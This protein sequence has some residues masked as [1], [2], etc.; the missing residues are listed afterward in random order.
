MASHD[1]DSL[2]PGP[3]VPATAP[4]AATIAV[5]TLLLL[6]AAACTERQKPSDPHEQVTAGW[7]AY[8]LADFTRAVTLFDDAAA[9]TPEKSD[10]HL[11]ALYGLA[12]SWNLRRPDADPVKAA[13]LFQKVVDQAPSH[14]LAAWSLLALA[15]IK[16]LVPVGDEPDYVAV[17]KAY[18][19]CI[20]RFPEHLAGEEAFLYLQSTLVATL[21]EDDARTGAAALEKFISNRPTSVFISPACSLLA[22]CYAALHQP[23]KRLAAMIKA[24]DTEER[25]PLN[26]VQDK[27]LGFWTIGTIAEFEAGDFDAAR[28]YYRRLIAEYPNDIRCYGAKVAL[29][30]MDEMETKLRQ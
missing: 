19:E 24:V 22:Q 21:S 3:Q 16:H 12:T 14:D 25:D 5:G 20:S 28:H 6:L 26:P 2:A 27:A 17:R 9:R 11:Q 18:Q 7:R 15:R 4:R 13:A 8:R 23:D 29:K 1:G 30:R 10:T